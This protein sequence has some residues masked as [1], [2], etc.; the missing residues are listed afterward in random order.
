LLLSSLRDFYHKIQGTSNDEPLAI[1]IPKEF[2]LK[3][4]MKHLSYTLVGEWRILLQDPILVA[5]GLP[6][7]DQWWIFKELMLIDRT[8][9]I[10]QE[11]SKCIEQIMRI[12]EYLKKG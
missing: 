2:K 10:R 6:T 1:P 11:D 3:E 9:W 5:W 12:F 4:V 8:L 7:A